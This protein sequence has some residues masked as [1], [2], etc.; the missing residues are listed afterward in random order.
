MKSVITEPVVAPD[1]TTYPCL[2]VLVDYRLDEERS[3]IVLFSSASEGV[4]VHADKGFPVGHHSTA[5]MPSMFKPFKGTI[6]L[7]N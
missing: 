3:Q 6:T 2:K 5:W 1:T 4:V 7:E